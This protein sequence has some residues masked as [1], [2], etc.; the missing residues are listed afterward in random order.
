VLTVAAPESRSVWA[1]D[2]YPASGLVRNRDL[3]VSRK[4]ARRPGCGQRP[5][6]PGL[7]PKGAA[8]GHEDVPTATSSEVPRATVGR[9]LRTIDADQCQVVRA[10]GTDEACR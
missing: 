3:D 1:S 8:H 10:G 2:H 4:G 7:K 5:A 9:F 6:R